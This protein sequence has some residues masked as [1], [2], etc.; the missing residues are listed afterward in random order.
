MKYYQNHA[1]VREQDSA[2]GNAVR[3]L[4]LYTGVADLAFASGDPSLLDACK[5]IFD[6]I[7]ER[8]MYITGSVGSAGFGERFSC[9]YDLPNHS[10]YSESCA[11]IALAMF[12]KRMLEIE[13]DGRYTD[14]MENALYN[15]TLA[16][17]NLDGD[18]FFYVNPLEVDP[19]ACKKNTDLAH[20]K[21]VR[22]TWFG[23][24]CCPPNIIRTLASL[25]QYIYLSLIHI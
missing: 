21:P 6:N 22:Q 9:D 17:M 4:Y 20:V 11:S 12:C 13:K 3:N 24:A 14:V 7:A 25:G 2:E 1:P 16:G 8:R 23:C 18:R 5:R 10:N 19:E 15:T